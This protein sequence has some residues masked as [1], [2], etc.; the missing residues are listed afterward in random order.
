M[1]DSR[2]DPESIRVEAGVEV[3]IEVRNDGSAQHNLTIDDLDLSTGTMSSGDVVTATVT[4][5]GGT[6]GFRCTFHPGMNGEIVAA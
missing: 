6:T 5:P 4:A 3:A 1:E 2:F